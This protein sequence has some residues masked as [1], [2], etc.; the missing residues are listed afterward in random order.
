MTQVQV[1][2]DG[3]LVATKPKSQA[4]TSLSGIEIG[5][6]GTA[7]VG[8]DWLVDDVAYTS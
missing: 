8:D 4:A 6:T 1:Y 3:S 7:T 5:S 2:L